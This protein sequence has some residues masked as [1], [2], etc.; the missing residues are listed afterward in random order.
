MPG[1][2]V[3]VHGAWSCPADWWLV[4]SLLT[5]QGI[6]VHA[7]DLPT[8]RAA[9]AG[10]A[11]DVS[12]LSDAVRAAVPPVVVIGWSYGGAVMNDLTLSGADVRRL[13]FVA[14]VPRPLDQSGD[15]FPPDGE[16][17]LDHIVFPNDATCV[18]DNEWF[19]ESDTATGT[20]SAE[21]RRHLRAHPRRP[22]T[23][24]AMLDPPTGEAFRMT[25]TTVILGESDP[26][27]PP[28]HRQWAM[29]HH[30]DVR[31]VPSDHFVLFR[32]P[33]A[34]ADVVIEALR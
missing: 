3:L 21:V 7:V 11:D 9:D 6:A 34:I 26:L 29:R 33:A 18:L 32:T 8:H 31:V 17:N 27:V 1:S 28:P 16:M 10:R 22:M 14:S 15:P 4:T 13:V 25:P 30:T 23:L 24:R 5:D 12:Q 19:I 2:A 20:L